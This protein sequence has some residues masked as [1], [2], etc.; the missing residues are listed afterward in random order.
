M[1]AG[2]HRRR[3]Q[4]HRTPECIGEAR[5]GK[6]LAAVWA[7]ASEPG[8]VSSSL[9]VEKHCSSERGCSEPAREAAAS[10][11]SSGEISSADKISPCR[12]FR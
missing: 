10:G 11:E 8:V 5:P 12:P 7:V 9:G 6:G 2:M 1:E 4:K 3:Q